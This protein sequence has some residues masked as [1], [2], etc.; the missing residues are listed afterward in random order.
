MSTTPVCGRPPASSTESRRASTSSGVASAGNSSGT[1]W[2][3]TPSARTAPV[4]TT[5]EP[6]TTSGWMPPA[7]PERMMRV[8]PP[9]ASS[10]KQTA[11]PAAP[12]PWEATVTG[13]PR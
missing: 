7:V 5:I 3:V 6:S 1:I 4:A 2:E 10:S 9:R 8:T 11:A 13:T 12:T